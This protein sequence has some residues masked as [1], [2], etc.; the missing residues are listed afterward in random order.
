MSSIASTFRSIVQSRKTCRRFQRDRVI[1]DSV[2]K[3]IF[4][5]TLVRKRDYGGVVSSL[6]PLHF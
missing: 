4:Q 1:P 2:I 6:F 5:S 3:D